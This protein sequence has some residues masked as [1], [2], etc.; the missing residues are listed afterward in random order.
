M[1]RN[2]KVEYSI[3][4]PISLDD[5]R[6]LVDRCEELPGK[7]SVIVKESK[8]YAPNDFEHGKITVH[9]DITNPE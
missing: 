7:S 2:M 5:L 4:E 3:E 9:G 8:T 6:W 1:A